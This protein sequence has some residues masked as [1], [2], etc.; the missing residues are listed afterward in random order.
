MKWSWNKREDAL[1]AEAEK[2]AVEAEAATER[3]E[4]IKAKRPEVERVA[5]AVTRQTIE[6]NGWTQRAKKAFS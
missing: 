1:R 5:R 6:I 3:L 4:R 2:A